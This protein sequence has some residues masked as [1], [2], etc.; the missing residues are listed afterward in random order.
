MVLVDAWRLAGMPSAKY[1]AAT[2]DLWLP[3]LEAFGELDA[4]LLIPAVAAQLI[5]VSGATVDRLLKS[6]GDAVLHA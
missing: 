2:M 5:T 4:K 3:K 1:L 6:A